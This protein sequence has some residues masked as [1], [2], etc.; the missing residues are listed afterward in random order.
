VFLFADFDGTLQVPVFSFSFPLSTLDFHGFPFRLF[1]ST[2]ELELFVVSRGWSSP[3]G[4]CLR[5][6]HSFTEVLSLLT[7][8]LQ[9][10][11][12]AQQTDDGLGF[13]TNINA[14]YLYQSLDDVCS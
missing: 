11:I 14:L 8:F 1:E 6:L 9:S 7:L 13:L 4:T 2:L 10:L 3:S 12:V 5:A